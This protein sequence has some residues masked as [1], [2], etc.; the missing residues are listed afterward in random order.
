M[1]PILA[2]IVVLGLL[3]AAFAATPERPPR[4]EE[5]LARYIE[6]SGG[7][8]ALRKITTRIM[9]GTVEVASLGATGEFE[10]KA[11]APDKQVS[12]IE[13]EGFGSIREGFDGRTAWAAAPFQGVRVKKG[14]ELTRTQR[15]ALFP[16]ELK[17]REAYDGFEVKGTENVNGKDAWVVEAKAPGGAVDRLYFDRESGLLLREETAIETPV[18]TLMF[19]SNLSDYRRVDG[20][21]V[22]FSIDM[23]KPVEMGFKV[24]FTEVI[25]NQAIP[26]TEFAQPSK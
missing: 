10:V 14:A 16:R 21:M 7:R 25:H 3:P 6:A 22:P 26:D 11:K 12:R 19:Q 4:A 24:R 9:R 5:I 15:S 18:A 23:P 17:L 20:V 2:I 8:D 13:F 1:K